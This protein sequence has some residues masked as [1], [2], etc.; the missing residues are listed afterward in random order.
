MTACAST[1][2]A[3]I[4]AQQL[5]QILAA[6][7]FW[8]VVSGGIG[9]WLVLPRG[10]SRGRMVGAMLSAVSLGLLASQ[11]PRL[12]DWSDAW[13]EQ[14]LFWALAAMTA[15]AAVA[16][17]SVRSPVYSAIWFGLTLLT[18]A[19]LF[20][21]QGAQFLAVATVVVYAGAILVTFLF[22]LML[23]QPEG[24]EYYDRISWGW[25]PSVFA[26]LCGVLIVGGLTYIVVDKDGD[27]HKLAALQQP[28]ALE[29]SQAPGGVLDDQHIATLGAQLFSRHLVSVEIAGTLLLVALVGAIAIVIHGK[30]RRRGDAY[31]SEGGPADG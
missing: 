14:S 11:L 17:I 2:I 20:L 26:P 12:G 15:I 22:V 4:S 30:Q 6:P 18:T 1:P 7:L 16:T 29:A 28:P 13:I 5:Q 9:I 25:L 27:S 3:A 10:R 8:A 31:M 19:G 24:H 23:A 21:I